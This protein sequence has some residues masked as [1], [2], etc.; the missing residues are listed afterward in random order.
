MNCEGTWKGV[1]L[2][3]EFGGCSWSLWMQ[4]TSHRFLFLM[5]STMSALGHA[6]QPTSRLNTSS[7]AIP[8]QDAKRKTL[9]YEKNRIHSFWEISAVDV[10]SV[11]VKLM[12][13]WEQLEWH[14]AEAGSHWRAVKMIQGQC[15]VLGWQVARGQERGWCWSQQTRRSE[16][17][18]ICV[19]QTHGE[20]KVFQNEQIFN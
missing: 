8:G 2:V 4:H 16:R 7:K 18:G 1:K 11:W 12:N 19:L 10:M 3:P 6:Q 9:I 14:R 20:S 13:L 17:R 15:A 5:F